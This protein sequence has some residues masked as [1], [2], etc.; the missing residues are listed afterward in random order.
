MRGLFAK[1]FL[2][3]WLGM[4]ALTAVLVASTVFADPGF[5]I[6]RWRNI[7]RGSLEAYALSMVEIYEHEGADALRQYAEHLEKRTQLNRYLLD[8]SGAEVSGRTAPPDVQQLAARTRASED[9][10]MTFLFRRTLAAC[11]LNGPSGK[12]YVFVC[13]LPREGRYGPLPKNPGA[14]IFRLLATLLIGGLACYWLA[15]H[16]TAPILKLR[17][18]TRRV[19]HGDLKAR[20]GDPVL[21][22]RNDELSDLA[23]DFDDMASRI[24]RLLTTQK[25]LLA[26]ISHELRSPL[27]RLSLALG[28]A[29]RKAGP[30]ASPELDRIE[31]E[32]ERLNELIQQL[33]TLA[34]L[35]NAADP[36]ATEEIRLDELLH[37][38]AADAAFEAEGQN[39][40]VSLRAASTVKAQGMR[41]LLRSAIENVV[42]NAIRYTPE[43]TAV[44]IGLDVEPAAR[45][46][47]I[48]I[49]DHGP[50]APEDALPKL[51]EPFYRVAESRDRKSG[52]AGLGL[53]ITARAFHLHGGSVVAR[54][55]PE[56]GLEMSLRL[57][58][59]R[60]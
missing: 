24:E 49:R 33:L 59:D 44:S 29:R 8:A 19:A 38:I 35:E 5:L 18:A 54:N 16:L 37:E 10:E 34:R 60:I 48:T 22:R 1:I 58:V 12:P 4:I 2:W 55:H 57:P 25:R 43:G 27:T 40:Q 26:D 50:G 28:L 21:Y 23:R 42:R 46:A 17:A 9:V 6:A 13:D 14:M 32:A 41:D 20:A 52:G 56:G 30:E 11:A 3:Y 39:R 51:F 7:T 53:A 45:Q 15:R 36:A 31:R 47:V